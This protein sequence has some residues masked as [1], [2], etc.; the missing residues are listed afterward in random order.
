[1]TFAKLIP[2]WC[3][4]MRDVISI[5]DQLSGKCFQ[6]RKLPWGRERVQIVS[7]YFAL[8]LLR[9]AALGRDL[10]SAGR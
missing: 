8:E 7:A 10:D 1:M 4:T 3:V 5:K 9:R 6:H 2:V